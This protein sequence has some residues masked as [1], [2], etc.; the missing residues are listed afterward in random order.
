MIITPNI[1][2]IER[3]LCDR[4]KQWA[5]QLAAAEMCFRIDPFAL[6]AIID[7]ESE[8]GEALTPAG[9]EGRSAQGFGLAQLHQDEHVSFLLAQF[10]DGKPLWAD[11]SIHI[12]Y[13]ARTFRRLVDSFATS[14][15]PDL[16]AAIAAF[17]IGIRK[18]R[19]ILSR[20][21]LIDA[22]IDARIAALDEATS[23][24][25][26]VSDVLDRRADFIGATLP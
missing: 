11:P 25:N 10:P 13:V 1:V 15:G 2:S 12:L 19:G 6:A 16:P 23:G 4:M 18:V 24:E 5:P 26:Y 7:R 8:G 21:A 20:R 3:R 17:D 9:P 22:S 14:D